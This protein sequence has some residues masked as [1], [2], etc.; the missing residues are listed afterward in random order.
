[1]K[2]FTGD[3]DVPSKED[4]F[5]DYVVNTFE[6]KAQECENFLSDFY[7]HGHYPQQDAIKKA[8]SIY[9]DIL[10]YKANETKLLERIRDQEK[11]LLDAKD[12]SE[13]V[14]S[15][16]NG[17]QK[18]IFDN[19]SRR[20]QFF[21]DDLQYI[22]ANP[23]AVEAYNSI[24]SI[25]TMEKPFQKI[26]ELPNLVSVLENKH[27]ELLNNEKNAAYELI[28][29]YRDEL[30]TYVQDFSKDIYSHY[31]N[32][33]TNQ[34]SFVDHAEKIIA[35]VAQE[36]TIRGIKEEG[37]NK[38]LNAKAPNRPTVEGASGEAE[39]PVASK[40]KEP[41]QMAKNSVIES[42]TLTTKSDVDNYVE[43]LK[44][45]LYAF[46]KDGGVKID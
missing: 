34:R 21:S 32:E 20:F 25:L 24:K 9:R 4:D 30:G 28:N 18:G 1:M 39:V 26:A 37:A 22:S 17:K 27:A 33:L 10:L 46:L 45:K 16:F 5:V 3:M 19:A 43:K 38:L 36:S 31:S 13:D 2:D 40:P 11:D 14:V 8:K 6:K 42:A 15:F 23:E 35:V 12:D 41:V 29:K 7:S 44:A